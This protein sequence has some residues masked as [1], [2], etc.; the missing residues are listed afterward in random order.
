MLPTPTG[1]PAY[2]EL[3]CMSHY[4]FLRGASSPEQLVDRAK[5][6]GYSAIAISDECSVTG[7]V[8]AHLAAKAAGIQLIVAS[9]MQI[10]NP[11]GTEAFR[12]LIVAPTREAYGNLCELI[13]IGRTRAPKGKYMVLA[14]DI[15]APANDMLHLR[16]L[17]ECFLIYLPKYGADVDEMMRVATWFDA[18]APGRSW[19]ALTLLHNAQDEAHK[20]LVRS[21]GRDVRLPIVAT[22][23]VSMHVRS[24]KP[25]QDT[26][27]AI[28][29]RLPL[30]ECGFLLSPNAEQHLRPR[31]RLANVY[32]RTEM[33]EGVKIASQCTFTLDELKYEYPVD[34]VPDG[35]CATSYLRKET[36]IGAHWRYPAGIP[37]NVQVQVERELKIIADLKFENYFLTV[38]DIVRFARSQNIL[39]Q[40]RGSAA[41][42]AVCYCL[43]ITEVD[44]SRGTLLFERFLS[45][46]RA[47]S[48]VDI[49][50][51]FPSQR[52]EEVIQYILRRYTTTRA[53]LTAVIT[54]Y[55]TK[56][57]LRDV[58]FALGIDE[59]VVIRVAKGGYSWGESASLM[60]R[61]A[62]CGLDPHSEIVQHW[63]SLSEAMFTFPRHLSQ[64]PGGFVI[65]RSK[66]TR[67][68]PI[69][70]AAMEG[71]T[72]IGWDKDD[73]EAV[74]LMKIDILSLGMLTCIQRALAFVAARRG[75]PF[76]LQDIPHED[77][78]TYDMISAADT[79]GLFQIESRSQMATLPRMK[80]KTFYDLVIEV[81]II[82]P[83]PIQG[84]MIE[85]FLR[86]RE[87][88]DP[89]TYPSPEMES[90]LSRTMGVP[91]F[92]EQ[93]MQIS[94]VAAGFTAGEADSLRRAMGAWKRKGH[95]SQFDEK[96]R[97]G[98][99]ANGYDQAF[100]DSIVEQ[101]KGFGDYGFPESHAASFA[102]IAYASAWLKCHEPEAFLAALL[103]SQPM[104]FYSVSQL[105]QDARRHG[106]DVLPACINVSMWDAELEY[107]ETGQPSVRLGLNIVGDL[108]REAAWRIE[109]SRAVKPF[110]SL[111]D[112][113]LRANLDARTLKLLASAGVLRAVSGNRREAIWAAAG[114]TVQRGLLREASIE[115]VPLVLPAPTE[116][117]E[118]VS[119]FRHM[120]M[121]LGRHPLAL[122]RPRL[123]KFDT[124]DELRSFDDR[125]IARCCGLVTMRQRPQT[126]GGVVFVTLEDETGSINVIV[127]PSLADRQRIELNGSSLMAVFGQWQ[128]RNNVGHL[129]AG[130]LVD[131]SDMLGS[132]E[133]SSRDYK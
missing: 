18:T 127:W 33:E 90:V 106:V 104:G 76:G 123:S 81:A 84:G 101:M 66:L 8:K 9:Q 39:C 25:V 88:V 59:S 67:V 11:D 5:E 52:R 10:S 130:R 2:A 125:Q 34:A 97:S 100:A 7:I 55:R 118:L 93:V 63:I 113:A 31:L 108:Q 111:H 73:I 98:M 124:A 51:D 29:H 19:I 64:H 132:L 77:R 46:D 50:V 70:N 69:E 23:D 22:G 86:R 60:D 27:A 17:P 116:G 49:D 72:V 40:G 57:V 78:A 43:G 14:S 82:R 128:L 129:V 4:T 3:Q 36:Y 6:L 37:G 15:D 62:N 95:F 89:V 110:E 102:L 114:S 21:V 91:I 79:V 41:N 48:D 54:S 38:F 45:A 131:L 35:E 119:D 20:D 121:T 94:M 53:A 75:E 83:G 44:P 99:L 92:Q 13:T 115:E 71:R 42:S 47:G 30:T 96:L 122:L 112:L 1:L 87:G 12:V 32:T 105:V 80:P 56:S 120:G 16:G 107:G 68:V 58:G 103:N 74:G 126:A 85:P 24:F 28:R 133:T 109:E 26:M 65:T 117:E 61:I